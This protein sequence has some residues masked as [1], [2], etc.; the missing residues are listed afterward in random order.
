M[1]LCDMSYGFFVVFLYVCYCEEN[2][3]CK[4]KVIY[5]SLN[6]GSFYLGFLDIIR[7]LFEVGV[8]VNVENNFGRIV[9]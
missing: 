3:G 6:Y 2:V 4:V 9:V 7:V 1:N 5:Y 8:K